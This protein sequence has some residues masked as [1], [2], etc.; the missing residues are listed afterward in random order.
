MRIF[1]Q[2][3]SARPPVTVTCPMCDFV[4]ADASDVEAHFAMAHEGIVEDRH[5]SPAH[6]ENVASSPPSDQAAQAECPMC[7]LLVDAD[8]I[9]AHVEQH[10]MGEP[11][12]LF[13]C[14]Y[15]L[16]YLFIIIV[17]W[18]LFSWFVFVTC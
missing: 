15:F 7:T 8:M 2:L 12:K 5:D 18:L 16:F 13:C 14:G 11:L 4:S 10:L 3:S 6:V 17:V 9:T 1:S